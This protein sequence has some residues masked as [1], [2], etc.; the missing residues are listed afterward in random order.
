MRIEVEVEVIKGGQARRFARIFRCLSFESCREHAVNDEEALIFLN[1]IDK[2][3]LEIK[4][5]FYCENTV[6]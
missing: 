3:L 5:D 2:I 1:G 6:E 4:K